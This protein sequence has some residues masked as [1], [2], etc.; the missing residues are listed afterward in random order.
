MTI[1]KFLLPSIMSCL[2]LSPTL[3]QLH[4]NRFDQKANVANMLDLLPD[5]PSYK[6]TVEEFS[7]DTMIS[8]TVDETFYNYVDRRWYFQNFHEDVNVAQMKT[9]SRLNDSVVLQINIIYRPAYSSADSLYVYQKE[10][11]IYKS[12]RLGQGKK[13][14][15]NYLYE[16]GN[17]VERIIDDSKS[18]ISSVKSVYKDGRIIGRIQKEQDH[19]SVEDYF[20]SDTLITL[21]SY[22]SSEKDSVNSK[23]EIQL[24]KD[25]NI[26][27]T[28]SFRRSPKS[29]EFES[30][31]TTTFR[32]E[33]NNIRRVKVEH[34][35]Q[36]EHTTETT[37][38]YDENGW[39][40]SIVRG[41]D[42]KFIMTK[43]RL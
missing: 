1:V 15:T 3:A 2:L 12:V 4:Y 21:V 36:P 13:I 7:H 31:M 8:K 22:H 39:K 25:Q 29:G 42:K 5:E 41:A 23:T 32:Y 6:I 9:Y 20:Y 35:R 24:D 33:G 17:L 40:Q 34:Y 14:T 26:V 11:E 16:N 18:G 10:G 19:I 30:S 38:V 28:Q 43:E 37:N 27:K